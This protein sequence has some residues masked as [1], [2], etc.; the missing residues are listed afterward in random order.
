MIALDPERGEE[1]WVFDPGIRDPDV[2]AAASRGVSSWLDAERAP[3]AACRRRLFLGNAVGQLIALDART[4]LPCIDFGEG[5]FVD[6][7]GAATDQYLRAFDVETGEELWK[8]H[9]PAGAHATPMTYRLREDGRQL[10][11]IAAG[12][13]PDLPT[14]RGDYVIAFALPP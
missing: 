11:V 6:L 12:G 1:R 8:A 14:A 3:G 10:V 2:G 4:G 13:H 9:L 7:I 5:G